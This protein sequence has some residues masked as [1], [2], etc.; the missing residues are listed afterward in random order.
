MKKI[1]ISFISIIITTSVFAQT[2]IY[3]DGISREAYA[4]GVY[5]G[6]QETV[7]VEEGPVVKQDV[8]VTQHVRKERVGLIRGTAMFVGSAIRLV[9]DTVGEGLYQGSQG[10]NA[11]N[12]APERIVNYDG[13]VTVIQQQLPSR[14]IVRYRE[15]CYYSS[16]VFGQVMREY[17]KEQFGE[18]FRYLTVSSYYCSAGVYYGE[19]VARFNDQNGRG[20][21]YAIQA[22]A[23]ATEMHM[24]K[25]I[26]KEKLINARVTFYQ[27]K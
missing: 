19:I 20:P 24:L 17:L 12:M 15:K 13:T 14:R 1:I 10:L 21:D 7:I 5:S 11:M 16:E 27:N 2:Y 22:S 23:R 9:G 18:N 6:S 8:I 3:G 4:P 26:I 25:F